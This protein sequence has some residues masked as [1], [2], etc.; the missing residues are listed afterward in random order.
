V[1]AAVM[2]RYT[3]GSQPKGRGGGHFPSVLQIGQHRHTSK[4]RQD[5]KHCGRTLKL[6]HH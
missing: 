3:A 2:K 6:H 1:R 5:N 4:H